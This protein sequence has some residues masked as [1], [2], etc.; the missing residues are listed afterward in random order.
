MN[1]LTTMTLTKK[2]TTVLAFV[3]LLGLTACITTDEINTAKD[4]HTMKAE[5]IIFPYVTI[6]GA[7]TPHRHMLKAPSKEVSFPLSAE[8]QE[9]TEAMLNQMINEET[10]AGLA[11]PQVGHH[12]RIIVYRVSEDCHKWRDDVKRTV[13]PSIL[14]NPSYEPVGDHK[15]ID[16]EGCFS[17]N[18]TFGEVRR[19]TKIKYQG[20]DLQ[21][22][23]ISGVAEGFEA[24]LL[25]HEIDHVN[26]VLCS[27]RYD[28]DLR[29]GPVDE[30]RELRKQELEAKKSKN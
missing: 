10:C 19:F 25:Q 16:W 15:T 21:G 22:H 20:Y 30:M 1:I 6:D 14:I 26:G 23:K 7:D 13:P 5:Q 24:R 8:H 9:I 29:H 12:L 4:E 28:I 27:D 17:V 2:L 3:S 18:K 11:A